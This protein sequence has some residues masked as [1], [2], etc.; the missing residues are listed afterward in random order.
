MPWNINLPTANHYDLNSEGLDGLIR[1]VADQ[2]IVAIDTETT[3]LITWKDVPLFWSLAWGEK[4][5][6]MPIE[7]LHAFKH[8]FED[9]NKAW[10]FANAKFDMHMLANVGTN[11]KGKIY[12]T[13]VMHS[14]IYEESPHNLKDMANSLLGWRWSDFFDTFKPQ[15]VDDGTPKGRKETIG[16]M[17][18]RVYRE[19]RQKLVEYASNDAYGTLKVFE[20][21][22]KEL[23]DEVIHSL[24]PD[25]YANMADIFYKTEAPFTKV[26]YT[27]ERNGIKVD[28]AH[29]KSI[30]VPVRKEIERIE[31]EIVSLAGRV[32]NPNSPLQLR[33]YFFEELKLKPL[34]ISKGGK[35]G[36]RN[37]SC[38][39]AFIDHYADEVP[40]AALIQEHRDLAKLLGTYVEG[41]QEHADANGRIHTH[42]NQSTARTGRLSSSEPNL[43]NIKRAEEDKFHLRKAFICEPGYS[44]IV[45]DYEQLEMRLLAAAAGEQKMIDIFMKNWDIHMGNAALVFGDKYQITYE[46]IEQAKKTDKKIK[47]GDLPAS[48]LTDKMKDCL[49][50]RQA[51]KS[52]GFGLNYGMKEKK[53]AKQIGVTIQEAKTMIEAYMDTYPTVA[54]FYQEAI[55]ETRKTGYAYTLLGRRRFLPEILSTR[56]DERWAAER[57]AGNTAIQGTAADA[58][59]MAMLH[60]YYSGLDTQFGCRMLLQVHDELV[61]ECPNEHVEAAKEI[62]RECMEHPFFTDLAVPLPCSMGHGPNWLEAK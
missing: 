56:E 43:Q 31:R 34:N 30:E 42:F 29:L 10:V 47:N 14:L 50:A 7:T 32:L 15:H 20:K 58:C 11:F 61:F 13:A 55:D 23:H 16:E 48:A 44:L 3:G 1:E 46:D 21:L 19:D 36:V 6:C 24:Y 4:R 35:T 38:D 41:L 33:Q 18:L 57:K 62:I 2:P 52:V 26:L 28:I 49:F 53:L 12:D 22:D 9:E 37:P 51:A 60:C 25:I 27:C 17:L 5:V 54:S 59:R 8:V 39:K 45:V 40:M